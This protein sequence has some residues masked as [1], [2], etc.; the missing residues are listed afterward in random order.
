MGAHLLVGAVV[1]VVKIVIA[2]EVYLGAC[3]VGIIGEGV[4]LRWSIC[5]DVS[6]GGSGEGGGCSG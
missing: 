5:A 4:N 6:E 3:R 1:G 2:S